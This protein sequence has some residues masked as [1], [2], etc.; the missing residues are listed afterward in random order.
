MVEQEGGVVKE[1]ET[2]MLQWSFLG[3][4]A[5]AFSYLMYMSFTRWTKIKG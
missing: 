2:T 4:F 5:L 3:I 1:S